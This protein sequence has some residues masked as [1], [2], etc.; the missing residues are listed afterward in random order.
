[1]NNLVPISTFSDI[2]DG[3]HATPKRTDS[4]PVYLGIKA[5]SPDGKLIENE[6]T[7]ISEEDYKIWTKRV[8]PTDGDIVFSYEATLGRYAIVPKGFRGSLGRRLAI[9][10]VKN[11]TVNPTWLYYFFRSKE[12]SRFVEN[13]TIVGS[14]VNRLS[15]DE[16]PTYKV[17]VPDRIIQDDMV[18]ILEAID[19]KID[20]NNKTNQKLEALARS[21]YN[22]WFV[23]H[24]FPTSGNKPYKSSGN[25]MVNSA[26]LERDIPKGWGSDAVGNLIK[27]QAGVSYS[28]DEISSGDG[29]PMINL[30]SID[31]NREYRDDKLKFY[32]G[33]VNESK[34]IV[35]GDML[36]AC[37]DLT[38]E[39]IIIGCP[40]FTPRH[41][42]KF[43]YSMDLSKINITSDKI[44][45]TYLYMTLRTDWYHK[46]IKRFASGTN[47]RHLDTK[48]V[49]RYTIELPPL[50]LQQK[51]ESVVRPMFEKIND[52]L[53]ENQELV[54]LRDWLLP[55]LINGQVTNGGER[56][57][58]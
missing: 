16:F 1:M 27:L 38:S 50:E 40:I 7:H 53:I 6:F 3:P 58:K 26:L 12:W 34:S 57:N 25:S 54:N 52:A 49:E 29:L 18:K 41:Y 15:I 23:Q 22:Y 8:T 5:I 44:L 31:K 47:V 36:L 21:I 45:P 42:K 11:D 55:L 28:S 48:G 39:G 46:Y 9:V 35:P 51:F 43:T 33:K 32:S 19:K 13:H 17:P 4:G 10:R 37:T 14:T 56:I 24:D 2:Y 30:G 20:L